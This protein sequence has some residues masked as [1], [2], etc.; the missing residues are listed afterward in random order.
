MNGHFRLFVRKSDGKLHTIELGGAEMRA[1]EVY[2]SRGGSDVTRISL[3]RSVAENVLSKLA[4][5][6]PKELSPEDSKLLKGLLKRGPQ[7]AVKTVLCRGA[8]FE[9]DLG[10][11]FV[12]S[13][14]LSDVKNWCGLQIEMGAEN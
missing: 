13:D 2:P 5:V 8:E 3:H 12:V 10:A 7:E 9:M 1:C 6:D 4:A 11:K 14:K